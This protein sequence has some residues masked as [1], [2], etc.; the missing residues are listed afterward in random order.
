MKKKYSRY[1]ATS[2]FFREVKPGVFLGD[3][4]LAAVVAVNNEMGGAK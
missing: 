4:L 2:D 1:I 3:L